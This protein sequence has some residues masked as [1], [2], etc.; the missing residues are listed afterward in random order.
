MF[1]LK[2]IF[3]FKAIQHLFPITEIALFEPNNQ[4]SPLL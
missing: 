1:N 3:E 4:N 2:Y